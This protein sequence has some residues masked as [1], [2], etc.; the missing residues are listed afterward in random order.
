[1]YVLQDGIV[2]ILF[3]CLFR[4]WTYY[5]LERLFHTCGSY[6]EVTQ[7]Y[8]K[9]DIPIYDGCVYRIIVN[10]RSEIARM[11]ANLITKPNRLSPHNN[12][13]R[14]NYCIIYTGVVHKVL[15]IYFIRY[16]L[17]IIC[18]KCFVVIF[19]FY[20]VEI[21]SL[22]AQYIT[23]VLTKHKESLE[24]P[25]NPEILQCGHTLNPILV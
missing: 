16:R 22:Q 13:I 7:W 12:I 11:R 21:K 23:N 17:Q 25:S 14:N 1:M 20:A 3:Y 15:P 2:Y 18:T 4:E 19:W 8:N 5:I 10:S 24:V 6:N 9:L